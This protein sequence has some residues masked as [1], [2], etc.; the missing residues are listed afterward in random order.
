MSPW[1]VEWLR[2]VRT[3]RWWIVVGLF[4]FFG[5]TGP[6][7]ARFLPDLLTRFAGEVQ[8]TMPDP[9]PA[10]GMAQFG[11]NAGQLGLLAV[12]VVAA[13]A[14]TFD[15]TPPWS[16]FLRTRVTHLGTIVVPRVVVP[17][18]LGAAA[19]VTGTVVAVGLTTTLIG[20]PDA[21]DVAVGTVLGVV[22]LAFAVAVVALAAS[23]ARTAVS[24]VL[25]SVGLLLAAPLLQLVPTVGDWMPS[26]LLG[27]TD[28]L[29]AGTP[30]SE[31]MPAVAVA[32]VTI[33]VL[34]T[35]AVVRLSRREV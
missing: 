34:V 28:A 4:V 26:R 15:A 2:L 13:G 18:A 8:V 29:L 35:V 32:A 11:S 20:A 16:A 33:P 14:L 25:L 21:V 9:T 31:L 22:Y 6:L 5:V 27:A 7:T 17:W 24:T 3:H 12:L 10:A 19:L 23:L 1:R 30:V